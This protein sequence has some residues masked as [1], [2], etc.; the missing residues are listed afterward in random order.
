[1]T[2]RG[3]VTLCQRSLG[4]TGDVEEIVVSSGGCGGD[5][6]PVGVVVV[7]QV[8]DVAPDELHV[9]LSVSSL[10]AATVNHVVQELS[11]LL[12]QNLCS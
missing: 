2:F 7:D 12:T 11:S 4:F 5:G 3:C 8:A 6:G 9:S 10:K 1:M